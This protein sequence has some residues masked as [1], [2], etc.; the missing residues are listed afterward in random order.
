MPDPN[1]KP[2]WNKSGGGFFKPTPM[3][4]AYQLAENYNGFGRLMRLW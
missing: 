1:N 4:K 2:S 3:I